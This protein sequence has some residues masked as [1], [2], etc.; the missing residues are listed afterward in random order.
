MLC[1]RS[2]DSRRQHFSPMLQ[3]LSGVQ[4]VP[5]VEAVVGCEITQGW[6]SLGSLAWFQH[7]LAV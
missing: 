4:F 2:E 7:C 5:E 1:R 6:K 3:K